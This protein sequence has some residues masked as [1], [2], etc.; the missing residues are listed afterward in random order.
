[1]NHII[2]IIIKIASEQSERDTVKVHINRHVC[3]IGCNS[4]YN[5]YSLIRNPFTSCV[6]VSEKIVLVRCMRVP[7][8]LSK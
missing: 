1:M 2:I 7:S 6:Q 4:M 8:N 5:T 3:M